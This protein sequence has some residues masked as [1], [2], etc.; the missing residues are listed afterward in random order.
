VVSAVDPQATV[1]F[2]YPIVAGAFSLFYAICAQWIFDANVG[3]EGLTKGLRQIHQFWFN[4]VGSAAGWLLGWTLL[5]RFLGCVIGPN[6]TC[7]T[8]A[9]DALVMLV[10][11]VGI[12]GHLPYATAGLLDGIREIGT[13][14]I[15]K[16]L[17]AIKPKDHP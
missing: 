16:F 8:S 5:P 9:G 7:E 4:L 14:A 1:A 11:L 15:E 13:K 2:W 3:G 17:D 10:A 6:Q 12:T